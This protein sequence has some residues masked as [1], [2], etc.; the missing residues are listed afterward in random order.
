VVE[1]GRVKLSESK[2]QGLFSIPPAVSVGDKLCFWKA[3]AVAQV[4]ERK[5][6]MSKT[7]SSHETAAPYGERRGPRK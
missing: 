4:P 5:V 2:I 3:F 6:A 1:L 7:F